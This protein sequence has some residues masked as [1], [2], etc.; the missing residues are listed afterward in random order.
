MVESAPSSSPAETNIKA[1]VTKRLKEELQRARRWRKLN[2]KSR[3]PIGKCQM[4]AR[5]QEDHGARG[6]TGPRRDE[7]MHLGEFQVKMQWH[8][9]K[10]E[11]IPG[12]NCLPNKSLGSER[13][14][15]CVPLKVGMFFRLQ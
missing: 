8:G 11:A 9:R 12:G 3:A 4:K 5:D 13:D 10:S 2:R 6:G 1:K 15:F 14:K 7:A